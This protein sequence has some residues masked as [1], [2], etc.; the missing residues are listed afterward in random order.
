MRNIISFVQYINGSVSGNQAP[1]FTDVLSD[2]TTIAEGDTLLFTFKATDSNGTTLEYSL[3]NNPEGSKIDSVSGLFSWVPGFEQAGSYIITAVVSDGVLTD[4]AKS[5]VVV[6]NVN[7]APVF[8]KALTDSI[9]IPYDQTFTFQYEASDPDGDTL[10]F[11]LGTTSP[12][13]A[14]ISSDGLFSWKPTK[15]QGGTYIITVKVTDGTVTVDTTVN[16]LTVNVTS[17]PGL[18]TVFSLK[19]N[20]PNPFNPTTKIEYSIPE[21][22]KVVMRIFNLLGQEVAVVVNNVQPA[23]NYVVNFDASNLT[24]G[25]YLYKIEAKNFSSVK[26]MILMK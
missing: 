26:K 4:T 16:K 10:T 22:S 6:T 9:L 2:S 7:R 25:I 13:G 5:V 1:T 12:Q 11:S 14:T 20:Y 21:E 19:Q 17:K 3:V 15:A 23:G 24:T 8:T 18:P